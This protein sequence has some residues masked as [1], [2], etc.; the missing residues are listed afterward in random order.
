MHLRLAFGDNDFKASQVYEGV[1]AWVR[2]NTPYKVLH[3][4]LA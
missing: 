2:E 4:R 3:S 1:A